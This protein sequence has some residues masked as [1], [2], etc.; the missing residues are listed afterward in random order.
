MPTKSLKRL[1]IGKRLVGDNLLYYT[2]LNK[3][4]LPFQDSPKA[5]K[6]QNNQIP[7]NSLAKLQN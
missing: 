4:G 3:T 5:I 7:E 6:L 2:A 1:S